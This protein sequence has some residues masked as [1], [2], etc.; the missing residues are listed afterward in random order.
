MRENTEII[1]DDKPKKKTTEDK[2]KVLMD[3][4][5]E[6]I[7]QMVND[8]FKKMDGLFDDKLDHYQFRM[9]NSLKSELR[10]WYTGYY[11]TL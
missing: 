2:L 11:N 10:R 6:R 4:Q 1:V 3:E 8:K 9:Y 7:E 5:Y